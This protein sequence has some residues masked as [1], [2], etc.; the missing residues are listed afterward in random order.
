ME[1]D[2]IDRI[3][4]MFRRRYRIKKAVNLAVSAVIVVLGITSLVFIWNCDGDGIMTFRWM[5]V[6]G[7][8]F[9]TAIALFYIII[10]ILEMVFY[11]ELTSRAVYYVRLA[12]AVAES[13][14]LIVV[15]LSR[16]PFSPD[17]MHIYRYDMFN[18]HLLIP[19]LTVLSFILNDSPIGKL[20]VRQKLHGMWFVML[21]AAVILTLVLTGV[22]PYDQIPYYFLD[23]EHMPA[24]VSV[25]WF[26]FIFVLSYLLSQCLS[27]LNRRLSWA[28][29][30]NVARDRHPN[31]TGVENR[32]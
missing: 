24:T 20:T 25:G 5:T 12:S 22:I 8:V 13:L 6:D 30:R 7:T 11:T 27:G 31:E 4:R 1:P 32:G 17:K 14:I 23:V 19:V 9:T 29:F 28:W 3:E 26:V 16:L 21:Y 15:L 18:M 10:G 2:K